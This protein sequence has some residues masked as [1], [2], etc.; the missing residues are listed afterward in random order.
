MPC[1]GARA[2]ILATDWARE[3]GWPEHRCATLA[4]AICLHLN[5]AVPLERGP[6]AHLLQAGAALDVIGLRHWQL[7]PETVASVLARHPRHDM[8][9]ASYPLFVAEAHPRTRAQLLHRWLLF[10]PLVRHSQFD[11]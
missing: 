6:E 5:V 9:K 7:T 4:D 2:A 1:F 10:G 8:K 11:E 3:R